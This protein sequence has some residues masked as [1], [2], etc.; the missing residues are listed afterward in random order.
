MTTNPSS[1]D[2]IA[3]V[4]ALQ[5]QTAVLRQIDQKID[6]IGRQLT[7]GQTPVRPE[8]AWKVTRNDALYS[9]ES[10]EES[11]RARAALLNHDLSTDDFRAEPY[12]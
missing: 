5:E 8:S 6:A 9:Y 3:I 12:A 10:G 4:A 7:L 2:G 1:L 11:A